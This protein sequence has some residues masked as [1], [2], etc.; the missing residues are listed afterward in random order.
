MCR[1]S[2]KEV[3]NKKHNSF[4]TCGSLLEAAPILHHAYHTRRASVGLCPM[5]IQS[6]LLATPCS[7]CTATSPWKN[8][9]DNITVDDSTTDASKFQAWA[10]VQHNL[11][12]AS[13]R[14]ADMDNNYFTISCNRGCITVSLRRSK[15]RVGGALP[16][17]RKI[18]PDWVGHRL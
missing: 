6:S 13:V 18:L 5:Q 16:S 14:L 17:P 12:D 1:H 8:T 3:M 15:E 10:P 11:V 4:T 7:A 9:S 2:S